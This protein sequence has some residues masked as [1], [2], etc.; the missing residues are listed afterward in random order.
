VVLA[1][2]P[3]LVSL[4]ATCPGVAEAVPIG[5]PLP[6]SDFFVPLLSLPRIFGTT[7]ET[8]PSTFPY[9]GTDAGRIDGW[10]DELGTTG[11]FLVGV[12]W[13]GNPLHTRDRERSFPLA[14]L[15]PIARLPGVRLLSLQK[16]YGLDQLAEVK[17]RFPITDLG[18]RLADFLDTAAVMRNLDL[19]VTADSSPAHL[20][21]AL[22]VPVWVALPFTADWRWM[23]GRSDSP[24][25]PS[26][27][28]F[29][30]P[31]FGDWDGVFAEMA[32]A[33]SRTLGERP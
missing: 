12:V 5:K 21:G 16:N 30:Q 8:I 9:V 25:Y 24:W 31:R 17:G 2:A 23:A 27:R 20:A 4:A 7:I 33:L 26:L 28:L 1:C 13:Q 18:P 22:G 15:E 32:T 11:D 29:R 10:R 19:V 3:P 14:T 6:G